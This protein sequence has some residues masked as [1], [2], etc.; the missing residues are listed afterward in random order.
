M[1]PLL[2]AAICLDAFQKKSN[3]AVRRPRIS[4]FSLPRLVE[5]IRDLADKGY[6]IRK[7]AVT[8]RVPKANQILN[9]NLESVKSF[10]LIFH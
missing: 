2:N 8:I 10:S 9:F 1:L 4:F 5:T 6:S 7:I 3:L